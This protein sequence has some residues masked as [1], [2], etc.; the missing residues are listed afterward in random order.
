MKKRKHRG[1][2]R[3]G[4]KSIDF[5]EFCFKPCCDPLGGS[6]E[7]RKKIEMRID[8]GLCPSCGK[9]PCECK[10][11]TLSPKAHSEREIWI[12]KRKCNN[13]SHNEKCKVS[14]VR[15]CTSFEKQ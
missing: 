1:F 8:N 11:T 13:C 12:A 3:N 2:K 7:Y 15:K 10:S 5:C 4:E 6:P 14:D 9:M